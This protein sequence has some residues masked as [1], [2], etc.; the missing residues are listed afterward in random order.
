MKQ[1]Y[2]FDLVDN[3]KKLK[4][5][6]VEGSK[7]EL[8]LLAKSEL[9]L[10]KGRYVFGYLS[11]KGS[12][13]FAKNCN[14][15][16]VV[17]D[18]LPEDGHKYE[19]VLVTK[20]STKE[21]GYIGIPVAKRPIIFIV[22]MLLV[23][24]CILVGLMVF[25]NGREASKIDME[26]LNPID[27]T[28]DTETTN[29]PSYDFQTQ[30]SYSI[31]DSNT[32]IKVWNPESN[33]RVFQYAVYIDDELV[34]ETKG[35]SPGNMV[36]VDCKSVLSEKGDHDLALDLTVLN[37]ETGDVVGRAQRNAVLTVK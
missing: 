20:V 2:S 14:R 34:S 16:K 30:G 15:L 4:K 10:S 23:A 17:L 36:E 7:Y 21:E 31:S 33:M 29:I 1:K 9:D 37:E 13:R 8:P 28:N 12:S 24:M 18:K 19:Y 3:Q 27:L 6:K 11:C 35:I 26:D 5:V 22:L 25:R 32:K